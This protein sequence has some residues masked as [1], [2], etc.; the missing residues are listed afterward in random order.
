MAA[1]CNPL[2]AFSR[3]LRR[4]VE[5]S[6]SLP[7]TQAATDCSFPNGRIRRRHGRRG[8]SLGSRGPRRLRTVKYIFA[9]VFW[10]AICSAAEG[11]ASSSA[12][13]IQQAELDP[14]QCYRVRDLSFQREDVKIYLNEGHLI[15]L[16]PVQGRRIA[17]VFAADVDGGDAE[18]MVFPPHTSER[19]SL[20]QFTK[21]PNL[22]EHFIASVFLFTDHTGE[23]L[24]DSVKE[25]KK[26]PAAG[27]VLKGQFDGV[28]RN[29]AQSYEMRLVYDL[30]SARM[31]E[32]WIFLRRHSAGRRSATSTCSTIA[33]LASRC[34]WAS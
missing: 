6:L 16:K 12:A 9:L 19:M 29:I 31:G 34:W 11:L 2:I 13:A 20:A 27:L 8:G 5:S 1:Q 10:S 4:H 22:D 32:E 21:S 33:G 28:V 15:F 25:A 30:L 3:C 24:L 17:A 7:E 14:E 18:L 26:D 23:E